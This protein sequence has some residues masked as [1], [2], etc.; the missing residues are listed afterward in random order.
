M[1]NLN[2]FQQ[3]PNFQNMQFVDPQSGELSA[4]WNLLL[5]QLFQALQANMSLQG[6][7]PPSQSSTTIA[8]IQPNAA[9]GT[10]IYNT[11]ANSAMINI[12]GTFKTITAT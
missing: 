9:N 6:L 12:N 7:V 8:T 10:I 11:T 3:I 4:A 1:A 5:S 2:I